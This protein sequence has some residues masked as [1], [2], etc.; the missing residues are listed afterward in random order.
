ML[1]HLCVFASAYVHVC[2]RTCAT[3]AIGRDC[4]SCGRWCW[5]S[6]W[7]TSTHARSVKL[8]QHLLSR[9]T[10]LRP[11]STSTGNLDPTPVA[12]PAPPKTHDIAPWQE[13]LTPLLNWHLHKKGPVRSTERHWSAV[14]AH[15]CLCLKRGLPQR[16]EQS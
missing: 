8:H 4:L 14:S 13:P 16:S 9:N 15:C 7:Q 11:T 3:Y 6:L 2:L 12:V 5:L 1:R 10:Q